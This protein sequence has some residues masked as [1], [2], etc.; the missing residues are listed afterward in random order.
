MRKFSRAPPDP[1]RGYQRKSPSCFLKKVGKTAIF[2]Y[3]KALG[4]SYQGENILRES[5]LPGGLGSK[6]FHLQCRRPDSSPGW[7]DPLQEEM[8][9]APVGL[10]GKSQGQRSLAGYTVTKSDY[11][12][13]LDMT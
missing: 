3:A 5:N 9:T 6:D 11:K 4:S 2:T 1:H 8:A 12:K 10:P 13:E 7:A